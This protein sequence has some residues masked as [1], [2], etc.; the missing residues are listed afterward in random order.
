MD[1]RLARET[2]EIRNITARARDAREGV[3]PAD[4]VDAALAD[5]ILAS[6]DAVVGQDAQDVRDIIAARTRLTAGTYGICVDCGEAITYERLLAYP[7]AKRCVHCQ[8][9]HEQGVA[10]AGNLRSN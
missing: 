10:G 4:W 2:D 6:D 3:A 9:L 7:T 1:A 8:R 5:S